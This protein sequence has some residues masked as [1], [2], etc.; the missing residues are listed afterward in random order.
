[1]SAG[2]GLHLLFLTD[3]VKSE[4]ETNNR[5]DPV[6]TARTNEATIP[7]A[8]EASF[9]NPILDPTIFQIGSKK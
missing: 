5:A 1:L 6:M 3:L 7:T 8:T 2:F 9:E 4:N